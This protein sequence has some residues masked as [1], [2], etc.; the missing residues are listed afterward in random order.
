[1]TYPGYTETLVNS[2]QS[3]RE[4]L[5][6]IQSSHGP[7]GLD[8]EFSGPALVGGFKPNGK[9]KYKDFINIY[10]SDIDGYSVATNG[11]AWYVP[12]RHYKGNAPWKP[13]LAA[14]RT[15]LSLER[16]IYIHNLK[17]ELQV[18]HNIGITGMSKYFIC[19]QVLAWITGHQAVK[20]YGLKQLSKKYLKYDMLSF[21]DAV[22]HRESFRVLSPEQGL[23]YACD[24]A[25]CALELGEKFYPVLKKWGLEQ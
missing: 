14:L 3:L 24:D 4:M 20:S 18:F 6:C 2:R 23:T 13:A 25:I 5:S 21:R 16:S 22:G 15:I 8:T 12:M 9:R 10:A 11:Q 19:T 17:N 1:M 7:I